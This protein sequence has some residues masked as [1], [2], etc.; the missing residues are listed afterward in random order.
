[1]SWVMNITAMPC[2]CLQALDQVEDLGLGRHVERGR[3]LVGDQQRADCRR[4]P[5]RSSRAGACRRRTRRCSG[6]PPFGLGDLDLPQQLD[7]ARARPAPCSC[8]RC[9]RSTSMIWSPTVCTGDSDDIGSWKIIAISRAAHGA[10][11]AAA[12]IELGE[13]DAGAV[14]ARCRIIEPATMR[15]GASTICR[16][17]RAVTL[18]PEPLSPT[19]QSVRPRSTSKDTPSTAFTTPLRT[20]NGSSR[21]RTCEDDAAIGRPRWRRPRS[22][23]LG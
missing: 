11:R 12:R 9:R 20:G 2:C 22:T 16:I 17:E 10:D 7:A 21:S 18:L 14:R 6:R 13:V 5:W 19:T 8:S 23:G 15:P 1:M 4:A 3:R